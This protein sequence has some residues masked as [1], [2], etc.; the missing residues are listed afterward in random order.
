MANCKSCGTRIGT[1]DRNCPNCGRTLGP[2]SALTGQKPL[3]ADLTAPS[4]EAAS[5]KVKPEP[6]PKSEPKSKPEAKTMPEP[7]LKPRPQAEPEL[8][9]TPEVELSEAVEEPAFGS[10]FSLGPEEL[11]ARISEDPTL[12]EPGLS[13]YRDPESGE[14]GGVEL[15]TEVGEIDLLAEDPEG[16]LVVV[17]VA[18]SDAGDVVGPVLEQMGWVSKHIAKDERSV[19]A[20]VLLEPPAPELGYAARAVADSVSFKTWRITVAVDDVTL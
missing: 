11:L 8:E 12:L 9:E 14:I 10:P 7:K 2:G 13:V 17:K 18:G 3:D 4:Q 15:S 20:L 6:K 16:A 19:R 1:R 5:P